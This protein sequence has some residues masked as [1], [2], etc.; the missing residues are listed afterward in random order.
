MTSRDGAVAV[1]V[2]GRSSPALVSGR[3]ASYRS[4]IG[5]TIHLPDYASGLNATATDPRPTHR[6]LLLGI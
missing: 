6:S 1:T 3:I 5:Q 4:G 2:R